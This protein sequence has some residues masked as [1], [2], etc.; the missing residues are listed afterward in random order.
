M[1]TWMKRILLQSMIKEFDLLIP[2]IRIK[3]TEAQQKFGAI[4]PD[5]F[6]KELVTD[7]QVWLCQ[8]LNIDPVSIGIKEN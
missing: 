7:I 3:L 2:F 1:I 4:P 6:S 5:E 8:R